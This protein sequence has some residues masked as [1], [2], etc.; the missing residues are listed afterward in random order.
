MPLV[1]ELALDSTFGGRQD[2]KKTEGEL[3]IKMTNIRTKGARVM[4]VV[5]PELVARNGELTSPSKK[6]ARCVS[7]SSAS[8]REPQVVVDGEILLNKLALVRLRWIFSKPTRRF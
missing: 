3:K 4:G 6:E 1:S 5:L 2:Q 8:G 7:I